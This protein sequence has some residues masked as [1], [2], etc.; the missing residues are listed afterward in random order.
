MQKR[1]GEKRHV[2]YSMYSSVIA[3]L[4]ILGCG[5]DIAGKF[6]KSGKAENGINL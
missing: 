4:L 2:I 3:F 6:E 5:L 1:C